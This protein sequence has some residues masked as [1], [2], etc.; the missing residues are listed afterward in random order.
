MCQH[1][2]HHHD[3][4]V[5][6]AESLQYDSLPSAPLLFSNVHYIDPSLSYLLVFSRKRLVM[7]ALRV[8]SLVVLIHAV[9]LFLLGIPP[10]SHVAYHYFTKYHPVARQ[11][12]VVATVNAAQTAEALGTGIEL[13]VFD[14]LSA[15]PNLSAEQVAESLNLPLRGVTPLL[16]VLAASDYLYVNGDG[17]YSN[18]VTAQYHLISNLP[19]EQD[20]GAVVK[21]MTSFPGQGHMASS[22]LQGGTTMMQ[23]AEV[24]SNAWWET[25][26]KVTS[27]MMSSTASDAAKLVAKT[28]NDTTTMKVL[29]IAAGSGTYGFAI[30]DK[31]HTAR[32]VQN[33]YENILQVTKQNAIDKG[34]D[35][36][37]IDFVNGNF[38]ET[39]FDASSFD[40]VLAPNILHHFSETTALAFFT[41]VHDLLKPGGLLLI[42]EICR[43][44]TPYSIW[45]GASC[46]TRTF[47]MTMLMWTVKGKAY[48]VT[49]MTQLLNKTGF[50]HAKLAGTSF[51]H[52]CF[53]TAT[54]PE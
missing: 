41:K 8:F 12:K 36:S 24:D 14:L 5:V 13:G 31:F 32:L 30:V 26:A 7:E 49:E 43:P 17:E 25:F 3:D 11:L 19:H 10:F 4:G 54:K 22:V 15:T 53:V 9:L 35:T 44:E 47:S 23:H 33:D 34:V 18:S 40:V 46:M 1:A 16:E 51:P 21:L 38:F 39:D 2:C 37:R 50:E 28:I 45:E 42:V 52:S 48:S 27:P 29:D 20:M 6:L